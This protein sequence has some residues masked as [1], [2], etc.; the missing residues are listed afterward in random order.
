[1][2]PK[3]GQVLA[4]LEDQAYIQLQQDCLTAKM[5]YLGKDVA[6]DRVVE[7]HCHLQ[8]A[9]A[10]LV[11]GMFMNADYATVLLPAFFPEW[12]F[13]DLARHMMM[14]VTQSIAGSRPS[15]N[16]RNLVR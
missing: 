10:A 1:V 14:P 12:L 2:H 13:R 7:I 4:E 6:Q 9:Y 11:P 15:I 16:H 3:K 8:Q 5:V